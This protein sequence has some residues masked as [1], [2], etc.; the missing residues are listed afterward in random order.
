MIRCIRDQNRDPA[1]E[2]PEV[3]EVAEGFGENLLTGGI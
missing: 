3:T 1:T 2:V